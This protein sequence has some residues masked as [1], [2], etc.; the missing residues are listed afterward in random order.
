MVEDLV[1]AVEELVELDPARLA[2][3]ETVVALHRTLARVEAVTARATAAWDA[4]RGWA[5][6][7]AKSG[8]AWLAWRTRLPQGTAKRMLRLGRAMRQ[9]PHAAAAWLAGEIAGAHVS[10]LAAAR[11]ERTA[12]AMERD[13]AMLVEEARKLRFSAFQRVVAYWEQHADPDGAERDAQRLVDGRRCDVSA[14]FQGAVV[15]DFVLDPIGGAIVTSE[16]QR[17]EDVFF[18]ADWAEAKERLGRDPLVVELARTPKQRRADALVEMAVRS[19]TAP[20]GGRRPAPLFSVLVG[21]ETFAGR[22]CELANGTVVTPGS[23]VP[24][25]SEA[26]VE[27]VVFDGPSRVID[28]G[29]TRR[30][31]TGGTRRSVEVRDQACFHDTCEER[32]HLQVDHIV[33]ASEGGPTT[34]ANGRLACGFHNRQRHRRP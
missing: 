26:E 29:E 6:D 14:T 16:L 7:G 24:Y 33:P 34:Q 10:R 12:E 4:E 13:E 31:F 32:D 27:R 22:I 3:G 18:K 5:A 11:N 20:E 15:G 25:L 17:I 30:F 28:V 9:L 1:A 19:R 23:L 8:A 2:D 21:Y